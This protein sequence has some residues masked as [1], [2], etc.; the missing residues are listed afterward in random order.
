MKS[1]EHKAPSEPSPHVEIGKEVVALQTL[2]HELIKDE[3]NALHRLNQEKCELIQNNA[4]LAH[5]CAELEFER[6]QENMNSYLKD[7]NSLGSTIRYKD[8]RYMLW[9][10]K[11]LGNISTDLKR[12]SEL[13]DA[14]F[15]N[16]LSDMKQVINNDLKNIKAYHERYYKMVNF[17]N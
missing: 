7:P 13:I 9:D 14:S 15:N 17:D 4:Q 5:K 2:Y 1:D 6:F 10:E 11:T 8:H 12:K 3:Y 16:M